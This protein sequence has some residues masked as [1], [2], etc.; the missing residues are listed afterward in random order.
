MSA[1]REAS[2]CKKPAW[3]GRL[4]A[5]LLE[6]QPGRPANHEEAVFPGEAARRSDLLQVAE[7]ETRPTCMILSPNFYLCCV[8]AVYCVKYVSLFFL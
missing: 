8:H 1:S 7:L 5:I 6:C 3:D 2:V 4:P